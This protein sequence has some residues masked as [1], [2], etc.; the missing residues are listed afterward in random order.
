MYKKLMSGFMTGVVLFLPCKMAGADL[1]ISGAGASL[2]YPI[3]SKWFDEYQRKFPGVR[4]NYQGIGSGGGIRQFTAKTIDFGAT[5]SPMSEREQSQ[6]NR[7]FF[8]VPTVLGG[9]VPAFNLQ[10]I[11]DLRFTG[12][13]IADIYLG[14]ITK[15]NDP[16]LK[17]LNP[18]V[19]LP[20]QE[21]VV[22]R[23]ADGSGTTFCFTDYLSTVSPSWR[24]RVGKGIS[25]NWPIGIGGKGNEGVSGLVRRTP[26][27]LGYIELL[28][29]K[30]NG[31]TY[32]SVR[33]QA[34]AFVKANVETV[35]A[36][37]ASVKMPEDFRVSIV[38]APG[39]NSYPISTFTWLLIDEKNTVETGAAIKGFLNWMLTDGQAIAP[40]LEYAPLPDDV[41]MMAKK[42]VGKIH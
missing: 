8:H 6:V 33:N 30:Q 39:E 31:I 10:G 11:N 14:E 7:P 37:G 32:G 9:V 18:D 21:I 4:F 5:D 42:V 34:G 20:N 2:P 19:N 27:S 24:Q 15:W 29:A 40:K 1:L 17:K 38:N 3:Y 35:R 26:Y 22:I 25:V 12:D 16:A 36:A 23:R 41:A 13:V 28:F